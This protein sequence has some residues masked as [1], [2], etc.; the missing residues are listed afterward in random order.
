MNV[1]AHDGKPIQASI[2]PPQRTADRVQ[3]D[4]SR[5]AATKI[6]GPV[7]AADRDVIGAPWMEPAIG[8]WHAT[9]TPHSTHST[10]R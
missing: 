5:F 10:H 6:K 9:I 1:V 3:Y 7:V 2:E 8:T 4:R